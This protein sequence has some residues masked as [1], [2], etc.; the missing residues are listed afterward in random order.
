MEPIKILVTAGKGGVG[1]SII[2]TNVARKLSETVKVAFIDADLEGS[3]SSTCFGVA[4]R[5]LEVDADGNKVIPIRISDHLE[6]VNVSSHPSVRNIHGTV[7]WEKETQEDF[8]RQV[9]TRMAWGFKPEVVII[10]CPAGVG[11]AIP[12]LKKVY[13]NI[14]G[15][16]L[17][18]TPAKVSIEN[19]EGVIRLLLDHKIPI[20]GMLSNMSYF[21]CGK[22]G[23]KEYPYGTNGVKDLAKKYSLYIYGELPFMMDI[24]GHMDRGEAISSELIDTIAAH[25]KEQIGMGAWFKKKLGIKSSPQS[26]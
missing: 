15:A 9:L 8:L 6:L 7:M 21:T 13:K 18:T 3:N 2:S 12:A 22:C 14:D 10:D 1:K 19:C 11:A 24:P 20:M 17:V 5:E 26:N 25:V 16:V 4:D 23:Q